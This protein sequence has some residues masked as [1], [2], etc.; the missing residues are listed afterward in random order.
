MSG[1][2]QFCG[3]Y[4]RTLHKDHIVPRAL[5]GAD[6]PT[7]WQ[8]LCANCHED[9][10]VAER[11]TPEWRAFASQQHRG[12]KWTP[13]QR[14]A[15]GDRQRGMKRGPYKSKKPPLTDEQR[16][17]IAAAWTPE[18]RAAAASRNKGRIAG[19]CPDDR[20]VK[21]SAALKGK[22]RSAEAKQKCRE[23]MLAHWA[24]VPEAER[25]EFGRRRASARWNAASRMQAGG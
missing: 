17:R 4:R 16:A 22:T 20:R 2:C 11:Q 19:P 13:E 1:T 23:K 25:A 21:I 9:K 6:D 7:N 5:G 14:K 18:M 10:T 15:Q 3:T 8:F 12:K 24:T